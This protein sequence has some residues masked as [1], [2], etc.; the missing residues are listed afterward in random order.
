M[1]LKLILLVYNHYTPFG[2]FALSIQQSIVSTFGEFLRKFQRFQRERYGRAHSTPS[3]LEDFIFIPYPKLHCVSTGLFM[4]LC[5]WITS[6]L[7]RVG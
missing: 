3:E 2:V 4:H 7:K 1:K 5:P 6:T